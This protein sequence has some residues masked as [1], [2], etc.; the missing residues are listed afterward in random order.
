MDLD[1][2][3]TS[4]TLAT[5]ALRSDGTPTIRTS[6]AAGATT[7]GASRFGR[8]V[9]HADKGRHRA[10]P[11]AARFVRHHPDGD[12]VVAGSEGREIGFGSW[13]GAGL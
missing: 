12:D 6:P 3:A 7:I 4:L 5:A 8:Y 10:V 13:H 1:V 2:A 9:G 11:L